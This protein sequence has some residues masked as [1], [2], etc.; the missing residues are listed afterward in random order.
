MKRAGALLLTFVAV[1]CGAAPEPAPAPPP[2]TAVT[3]STKFVHDTVKGYVTASAEQMAEADYAFKPAGVAAEVRSFGQ[4]I[5]HIADSNYFFC[6]LVSGE[7]N[8]NPG[9]EKMTA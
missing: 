1:G 7:A 2:S 5:G 9:A 4:L 6:S 8:P 3:D